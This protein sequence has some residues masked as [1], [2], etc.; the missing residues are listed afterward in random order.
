MRSARGH[1]L[2]W[3]GLSLSP[4]TKLPSPEMIK[5]RIETMAATL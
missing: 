4:D 3:V 1:D 5:A 2:G